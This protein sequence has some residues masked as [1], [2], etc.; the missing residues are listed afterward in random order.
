MRHG[1]LLG[2]RLTDHAAQRAQQRGLG[3]RAVELVL[4]LHDRAVHVGDGM[5]AWSVSHAR[6]R[7][8]RMA[9]LPWSL[10]ERVART[11]LVVEPLTG[12]VATVIN[13]HPDAHR[14]YRKGAGE[15]EKWAFKAAA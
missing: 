5:E 1:S 15:R 11:I 4:S 9:G 13:G 8:L 3:Q 14:R 6:C 2:F 10:I 12:T 7:S